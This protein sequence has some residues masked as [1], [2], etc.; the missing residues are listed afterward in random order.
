MSFDPNKTFLVLGWD[1]TESVFSSLREP[2]RARPMPFGSDFSQGCLFPEKL[3]GEN[4]LLPRIEVGLIV[5]V[6]EGGLGRK[7][8]K[9][10]GEEK[11]DE[12]GLE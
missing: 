7:P 4:G 3:W 5:S 6:S 1:T 2:T 11:K 9:N 12:M 10:L 8:L